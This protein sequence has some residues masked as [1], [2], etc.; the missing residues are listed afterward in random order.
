MYFPP[1]NFTPLGQ[2]NNKFFFHWIYS[3]H[4]IFLF[5][6]P[7]LFWLVWY[8]LSAFHISQHILSILFFTSP[9]VY[10]FFCSFFSYIL[11][12]FPHIL[13]HVNNCHTFISPFY[14]SFPQSLYTTVFL[15]C[16][17]QTIILFFSA[18]LL[19]LDTF[20][21]CTLQPFLFIFLPWLPFCILIIRP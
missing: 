17:E 12:F 4:N 13:L 5:L 6:K 8:G 15:P 9:S 2:M 11:P 16:W 21:L 18:D 7:T 14:I 1:A 10:S 3:T 19:H 20:P